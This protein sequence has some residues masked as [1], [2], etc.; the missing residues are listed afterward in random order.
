MW[1]LH[2]S[3]VLQQP[4]LSWERTF[5]AGTDVESR[6]ELH[7]VWLGYGYTLCLG[8]GLFVTPGVGAYVSRIS[9]E[10]RGGGEV[11]KRRFSTVS[12]MLEAEVAWRP[13]GRMHVTGEVRLVLDEALGL[14]SPTRV[15]DVALRTHLRV[16]S[17]AEVT[18][19]V[20]ATTVA[21]HDEQ[22][23]PNDY[24]VE[25]LPWFSLGLELR[26]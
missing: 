6:T 26:F 12:P 11:A 14:T 5:P 18:L 4:L 21:H 8:R 17:C 7:E 24:L 10:V 20:G 15:I 22:P 19:G 2:G 9:Y 23:V 13:G 1:V 3:E 16:S 25:V